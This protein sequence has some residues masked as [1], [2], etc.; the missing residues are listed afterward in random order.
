MHLAEFYDA[1]EMNNFTL[2]IGE[3]F[4]PKALLILT[5]KN[6]SAENRYTYLSEVYVN[7]QNQDVWCNSRRVITDNRLYSSKKSNKQYGGISCYKF[8]KGSNLIADNGACKPN[9]V[10]GDRAIFV[11]VPVNQQ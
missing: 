8:I 6:T 4:K 5:M 7:G 2:K 3:N 1:D 10:F 11:C 9:D